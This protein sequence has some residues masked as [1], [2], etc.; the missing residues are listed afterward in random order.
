MKRD[1]SVFHFKQF[2][3]K[4]NATALKVTTDAVVFGSWIDFSG[5]SKILDIGTGSG[6]L[7]LMAA[8]KS[9]N[10]AICAI[11]IDT[12]AAAEAAYNFQQSK[13]SNR[14]KVLNCDFND[15][16]TEEQFDVIISN[17]PYFQEALVSKND[18]VAVAKHT[19]SLSHSQ[20][21]HGTS[22]LL[23]EHGKAF[24]VLPFSI[25]EQFC[26]LAKSFGLY[27]NHLTSVSSSVDKSPYLA[28]VSLEKKQKS[29]D[30]EHFYLFEQ[31]G[32]KSVEY[33]SLS[34]DF[35]L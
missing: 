23:A 7:A 19:V 15:F 9:A 34:A 6:I 26:I 16:Y 10:A 31:N 13:W 28:M 14:F 5:A 32:A 3:V 21:L 12:K 2:A 20:L 4:H 33:Q 18:N 25:H 30:K 29:I 1:K 11:E 8:Q 27:C 17:P 24:F 35:Y 22:K